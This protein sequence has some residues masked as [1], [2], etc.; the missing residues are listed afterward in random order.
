VLYRTV[1]ERWPLFRER[2]EESVRLPRFLVQESYAS[3]RA[4]G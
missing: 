3:A 4:F 1:A 2:L